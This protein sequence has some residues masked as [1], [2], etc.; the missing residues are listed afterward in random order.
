MLQQNTGASKEATAV[1]KNNNIQCIHC[2]NHCEQLIDN[3]QTTVIT[4]ALK[5]LAEPCDSAD[6]CKGA[7]VLVYVRLQLV[8]LLRTCIQYVGSFLTKRRRLAIDKRRSPQDNFFFRT[9]Q[10][11]LVVQVLERGATRNF[12]YRMFGLGGIRFFLTQ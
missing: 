9:A 5:R 12:C 4:G 10:E 2:A 11:V 7:R 1:S 3:W 6:D 8:P